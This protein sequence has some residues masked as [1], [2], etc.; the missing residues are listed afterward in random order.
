MKYD[1]FDILI[2]TSTFNQPLLFTPYWTILLLLF[3]AIKKAVMYP[4]HL[5]PSKSQW[6]SPQCIIFRM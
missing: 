1:S 4:S 2:I 5:R 6:S 3:L